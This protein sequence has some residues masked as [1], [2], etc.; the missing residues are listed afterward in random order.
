[1]YGIVRLILCIVSIIAIIL[2]S[3]T[4]I[5][6]VA[7]ITVTIAIILSAFLLS[8]FPFENLLITFLTPESAY[9]YYYG[10]TDNKTVIA[11]QNSNLVVGT[12]DNTDLYLIVPKTR[13]GWKIGVG[14]DTQKISQQIIGDISVSVYQ[15]NV[16][17]DRYL[18]ILDTSGDTLAITAS[19]N[20]EFTFRNKENKKTDKTVSAYYAFISVSQEN[21]IQITKS[22]GQLF[23]LVIDTNGN[24]KVKSNV[25]QMTDDGSVS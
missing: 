10:A 5:P 12:R 19:P 17:N 1:M 14:L 2:L 25:A 21:T 6:K 11:G 9:T 22:S 4:H 23:E 18:V 8:I 13:S 7:R 20:T 24:A 15:H 3:K 16:S